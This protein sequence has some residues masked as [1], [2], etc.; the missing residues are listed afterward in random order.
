MKQLTLALFVAIAAVLTGCYAPGTRN[1]PLDPEGTSY[2]PVTN[3]VTN[4]SGTVVN[5]PPYV[6]GM[7][8]PEANKPARVQISWPVRSTALSV[9][10]YYTN[11]TFAFPA[12]AVATFSGSSTTQATVTVSPL[13]Q[14]NMFYVRYFFSSSNATIQSNTIGTWR[15][16]GSPVVASA[17]QVDLSIR[18]FTPFLAFVSG[19]T[20][21]VYQNTT[22]VWN[23]V[24]GNVPSTNNL[25]TISLA[26]GG[27]NGDIPYVVYVPADNFGAKT[28][29]FKYI[30]GVWTEISGIPALATTNALTNSLYCNPS[31]G[32]VYVIIRNGWSPNLEV[33]KESAAIWNTYGGSF[34]ASLTHAR[35]TPGIAIQPGTGNMIATTMNNLTLGEIYSYNGATWITYNAGSSYGSGTSSPKSTIQRIASD[36]SSM[37]VACISR[38]ATGYI[39][40]YSVSGGSWTLLNGPSETPMENELDLRLSKG[41][42]LVA[43]RRNSGG[44]A[45][46]WKYNSP[47]W[48]LVG[49]SVSVGATVGNSMKMNV[50]D[51][52]VPYLAYELSGQVTVWR[53]EPY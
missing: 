52:G 35:S 36:S 8:R 21:A 37:Y 53:Y 25:E 1:N 23:Q 28:R 10:V 5:D 38:A 19:S 40:L 41:I 39:D 27:V 6:L 20:A 29:S 33:L 14:T 34:A 49:P 48:S 43:Y 17:K 50:D 47:T 13:A 22:G 32:S 18:G 9:S 11:D 45:T 44:Q 2:V 31:D 46:V 26:S 7:S 12:S 15:T 16:Y 42:P 51:D 30:T 4:S 3:I 24:G